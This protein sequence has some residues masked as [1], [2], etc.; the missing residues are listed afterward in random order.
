MQFVDLDQTLADID[1]GEEPNPELLRIWGR[2]F[3]NWR[4]W[5]EPLEQPC[6]VLLAKL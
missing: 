4:G 2:S 1:N 6:V 3:G 5:P